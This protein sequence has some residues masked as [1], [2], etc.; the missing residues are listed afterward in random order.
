MLDKEA[1]TVNGELVSF[2]KRV[3]VGQHLLR[4]ALRFF[5]RAGTATAFGAGVAVREALK[6]RFFSLTKT[7]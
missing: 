4:G 5:D 3:G 2:G 6:E 1:G 7:E